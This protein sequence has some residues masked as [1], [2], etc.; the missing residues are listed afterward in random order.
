M[1][2]KFN[3]SFLNPWQ[4]RVLA[5]L[6]IVTGYLFLLHG[7]AKLFQMPHIASMDG[8]QLMSMYGAT[9]VIELAC[10]LL[11][12]LGLFTRPAAF[13]AS[14]EMAFA[15]FMGHA[16]KGTPLFPAA[17]G[18]DAAVLY[19]FIFLYIFVA[20]PGAWALGKR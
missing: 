4:P 16:A 6:R 20:G 11:V 13:L 14:G 1:T 8:V 2:M 7:S 3:S 19:C 10:G 5:L 12:L 18:G 17:N 9:A 15:Y